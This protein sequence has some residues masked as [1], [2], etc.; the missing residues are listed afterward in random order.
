MTNLDL[1]DIARTAKTYD[2]AQFYVV[3]PLLDQKELVEKIVTHWTRG[4]GSQY[5]GSRKAALD[6]IRVEDSL[7]DVKRHIAGKGNGDPTTVVTS[8]GYLD[9]SIGYKALK[10]R[11]ET[12]SPYLLVFGTAWGLA[13]ELLTSADLAL[14]PIKGNNGYNHL[15]VRCAAAII[16]DRLVGKIEHI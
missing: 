5:N 10:E 15:P 3:T 7:K 6:L 9:N 8:A 16:L 4:P 11:L 13:D 2:L 14:A 1:H 12:G